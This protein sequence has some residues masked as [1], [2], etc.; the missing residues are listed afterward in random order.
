M[1]K[2]TIFRFTYGY[3]IFHIL[4]I[5]E[6]NLARQKSGKFSGKISQQSKYICLETVFG[7]VPFY[8]IQIIDFFWKIEI[9]WF[10]DLS[11]L[12]RG[13]H[14]KMNNTTND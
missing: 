5:Y 2:I 6:K 8:A 4:R 11:P 3:H 13:P 10:I 14:G 12:P 7:C 9:H 1:S